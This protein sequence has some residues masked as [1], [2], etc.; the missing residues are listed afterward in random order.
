MSGPMSRDYLSEL[1]AGVPPSYHAGPGWPFLAE[2]LRVDPVFRE[3][4]AEASG[5]F[6]FDIAE[7]DLPTATAAL[8]AL[9]DDAGSARLAAALAPFRA[10]NPGDEGPAAAI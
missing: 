1:L 7:H 2:V 3:V 10:P 8:R 9:P 6:A 5:G 4:F